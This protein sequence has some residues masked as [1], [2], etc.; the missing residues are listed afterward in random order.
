MRQ[1]IPLFGFFVGL[2]LP[3]IAVA[4]LYFPFNNGSDFYTYFVKVFRRPDLGA[5]VLSL[6]L[7]A[8]VLPIIYFNRKRY[9]YA[10]RGLLSSF[11]IYALVIL[12]MRFVF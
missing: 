12:L 4:L 2:V 11:I 1:N 5:K 8:N 3:L 7:I 9:D 10:I 6:A